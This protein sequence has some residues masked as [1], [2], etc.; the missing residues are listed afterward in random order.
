MSL[1]MGFHST[2]GSEREQIAEAW[3]KYKNACSERGLTARKAY[4]S[5]ERGVAYCITEAAS[6]EAVR[7]AH[8]SVNIPL[9]DVY[10]VGV[11]K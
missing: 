9:D 5:E 10:A 3:N 7:E 8:Q 2:L 11:L 6:D 1:F 4:Y